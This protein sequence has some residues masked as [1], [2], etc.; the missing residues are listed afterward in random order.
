MVMESPREG[1]GAGSPHS[2]RL[3]FAATSVCL[4]HLFASCVGIFSN[5]QNPWQDEKGQALQA[6]FVAGL[7]VLQWAVSLASVS[8]SS[9]ALEERVSADSRL[10]CS[11]FIQPQLNLSNQSQG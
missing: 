1:F 5:L 8:V 11:V 10:A 7:P 3:A 2:L 9:S 6:L 4:P